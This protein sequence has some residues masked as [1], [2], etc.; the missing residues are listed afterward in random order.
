MWGRRE[1]RRKFDV[2]VN[3]TGC[4]NSW[5]SL[6]ILVVADIERRIMHRMRV[7]KPL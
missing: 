5:K 6:D 3:C 4:L 2:V 1:W 7:S